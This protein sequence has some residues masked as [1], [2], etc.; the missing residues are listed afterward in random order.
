M[1]NFIQIAFISIGLLFLQKLDAQDISIQIQPEY[2]AICAGEG[3]QLA[4]AATGNNLQYQWQYRRGNDFIA[5]L[6][7]QQYS[8]SDSPNLTISAIFSNRNRWNYRCQISNGTE[9]VFSKEVKTTLRNAA[10]AHQ[11]KDVTGYV[12]DAVNFHL[13]ASGAQLTFQW[14][15]DT[16]EGFADL[17][18]GK[19]F[20]GTK[21]DIL[22]ISNIKMDMNDVR[23]RCIVTGA[24]CEPIVL[25]SNDALLTVQ[26]GINTLKNSMPNTGTP[27]LYF[28]GPTLTGSGVTNAVFLDGATITVDGGI[29]VANGST[30]LGTYNSKFNLTGDLAKTGV[31]GVGAILLEPND[32]T[33]FTFSGGNPQEIS[34]NG[35]FNFHRVEINKSSSADELTLMTN[36]DIRK[37]LVFGTGDINLN[38]QDIAL[39]FVEYP[40][41]PTGVCPDISAGCP[42]SLS[43][44]NLFD[45]PT[46][47]NES[48]DN[49]IKGSTGKI[50]IENQE[51]A[52]NGNPFLNGLNLGNMGIELTNM[53]GN[54][55]L[56]DVLTFTRKHNT[57]TINGGNSVD[58]TYDIQRNNTS[59]NTDLDYKFHYLDGEVPGTVSYESNLVF[60]RSIDNGASWNI[61]FADENDATANYI[62]KNDIED[63]TQLRTLAD[64]GNI[65]I[66]SNPF[67]SSQVCYGESVTVTP[68]IS[69]GPA[70]YFT[71]EIINPTGTYLTSNTTGSYTMVGSEDS[72]QMQIMKCTA[73]NSSGCYTSVEIG[74]EHIEIPI[75]D[76]GDDQFLCENESIQL[77]AQSTD[78]MDWIDWNLN[79]TIVSND[80]N[81]TYVSDG[82]GIA[83]IQL[84]VTNLYGCAASDTLIIT[85][86]PNP[87]VDIGSVIIVCETGAQITIDAGTDGNQYNWTPGGAATQ[88]ISPTITNENT[89]Y[90][91]TVTNTTTTC[92]TTDNVVVVLSDVQPLETHTDIN[93]FG[94]STGTIDLNGSGDPQIIFDY[95]WIGPNGF[96][97]T[98]KDVDNLFAGN[99][100]VTIT[101]N[102]GCTKTFP[103]DIVIAQPSA[104]LSVAEVVSNVTCF[105]GNDG[106]IILNPSGGTPNGSS[107]LYN[108]SWVGPNAFM[109]TAANINGLIAGDYTIQ[110]TD[111]NACVFNKIIT[112][113]EAPAMASTLTFTSVSC[114]GEA[115]GEID[116]IPAGGTPGSPSYTF[117]W[118]G[119]NGFA[120]TTEDLTGLI[121][122]LYSVTITDGNLCTQT[123]SHN[124]FQP[125][126]IIVNEVLTSVSCFAGNDGQISL[127]NNNSNG[128]SFDL[129]FAWS[130]TLGGPIASTSEV[131]TNLVADVYSVT[132]TENYSCS[133]SVVPGCSIVETYQISEPTGINA[134]ANITD[135]SGCINNGTIDL[136]PTGGTGILSY[137]WSN[138]ATTQDINGLAVGDYTVQI[139]DANSCIFNSPIF[140]ISAV[141]GIMVTETI[142]P[143][144]CNNTNDGAIDINVTGGTSPYNYSWQLAN[145]STSNSQ[146]LSGLIPGNYNLT[147]TDNLGCTIIEMYTLTEPLVLTATA[148]TI[149][150]SCNSGNDGQITVN[151]SGGT[152]PFTYLWSANVG[153][154]TTQIVANLVADDYTVTV[155]DNNLCQIIKIFTVTQPQPL[156]ANPIVSIEL[157]CF[158]DT[159]GQLNANGSGGTSPLTYL[160]SNSVTTQFNSN[161]A[162][163]MYSVTITDAK[164]CTA[165]G[166]V[167][168]NAPTEINITETISNVTIFDGN[169]GAIDLAISGGTPGVPNYS[170]NWTGPNGFTATTEDIT[171]LSAGFYNVTVTDGNFCLK[172]AILEITEPNFLSVDLD[173]SSNISCNNGSDGS[174]SITTIGGVSPFTFSWAGPNGFTS[175]DENISML[176]VGSYQVTVTDANGAIASLSAPEVLTEPTVL[177]LSELINDVTCYGGNDGSI[178]LTPTGATPPFTYLWSL[179]NQTTTGIFN[180]AAGNYSVVITD[181]NGCINNGNFTISEPTELSIAGTVTDATFFGA[182]DGAV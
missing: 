20:A 150:V 89:N 163:A 56:G 24:A 69:N 170:F 99:Y 85:E 130:S 134:T 152:S 58:R 10:F 180:Q 46:I 23:F 146:N 102:F 47:I 57:F 96:T 132:V 128:C 112:V 135:A 125:S 84:T 164:A 33:I 149:N 177:S 175:T 113:G 138:G 167:N 55:L 160:W 16:G 137:L 4:V 122:G 48:D 49:R 30:I 83:D 97:S 176:S 114:F 106:Q 50:I 143:I 168:L 6:D 71:W 67:G 43:N 44:G 14:Q 15:M 12:G 142:S 131:L 86:A 147:V 9:T 72:T 78:P 182:S 73:F 87:I 98:A 5:V 159:D 25:T 79:G 154:Q 41:M 2:S 120:A 53:T 95:S 178:Q 37:S 141:A 136:V 109:A 179:N 8:G 60:F 19:K 39:T 17:A 148:T 127:A 40:N 7:N 45:F 18:E 133:G 88:T 103:N 54:S 81:Y 155:T 126:E 68:I 27:V 52:S 32:S 90:S 80:V 119:P 63:I 92:S 145:G 100:N 21:G 22:S 61:E 124:L 139:T 165:T 123:L 82:V 110:M 35:I 51:I 166:S 121:A 173:A 13:V 111:A 108:Y 29:E 34:G 76:L 162:P 11:P 153:N 157:E 105:G 1:G 3:T 172:T 101:D 70:A 38:G 62:Q 93:C 66:L 77:V 158:D 117:N 151:P 36:I 74:V 91:V 156:V 129:T 169:D 42:L 64:C 104:A 140:T 161:L 115:D 59:A 75:L 94:D 26:T 65:P 107:P 28:A 171:T 116:L 31:V 181:A 118:T 144:T 174:I